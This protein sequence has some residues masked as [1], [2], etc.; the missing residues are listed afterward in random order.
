VIQHP[1]DRRPAITPQLAMRVA[2]L[3]GVAFALFAIVFFRLWFLQVLTGDQYL[4][5]A[6]NNRVRDVPF[7]APR[8][9]IVDRNGTV[10]VSSRAALTVQLD[11]QKVPAVEKALAAEYGRRAAAA[12]RQRRR[13]HAKPAARVAVPPLPA[14]ARELDAL[15]RRLGR[16]LALSP[17]RIHRRVV[18]QLAQTPYANVTLKTDVPRTVSGYLQERQFQFPGLEV[19]P[20]YL[21]K[22]PNKRLA[23]QL[24]GTVGQISPDELGQERFRGVKQG[25]VVGQS[26][27]EY[28]Y[29]RYLRG[30]DGA[31]KVQVNALGDQKGVVRRDPP[32]AGKQLKLS[33]DLGLQAEGQRA[34]QVAIGLANRNS[35]PANAGGFVA[36]DPRDGAILAMGSVPSFDPNVF[37]RPLSRSKF[38]AIRD[39]PG[40]PL[41]NRAL[42]GL[43]PTGST[44]KPITA[45]A[46][47][48]SGVIDPYTNVYDSGC[49][50][51]GEQE[52]CNAGKVPYGPVNITRAL[53]VSSDVFFYTMGQ[54]LNPLKG[55]PLQRWARRLGLGRLTGVDVPGEVTGTVP[56]R[57]WRARVAERELRCEKRRHVPACGISDKRPWTVGDNVNLAVG[58][59]DLQASPLQMAVA[60]AALAN[61]G[62]VVRPHLGLEAEDNAGRV[63]QRIDPGS[64]RHVPM[65]GAA[66][67]AILDG[68]HLAASTPQGTSGDVFRGWPQDVYPVYGKTGTAQ[69]GLNPDQSWYVCFVP[70]KA[71]PIVVAVTIEKGGFGAEAAAPAA[72]LILSKWFNIRGKVVA[73]SSHTR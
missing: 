22:Y 1:D 52:R 63:L 56:D 51:I 49:I 55:Q 29:D 65:N 40:A 47:M 25:T 18:E 41:Y 48:S 34:M 62:R 71:R 32:V 9:D 19:Q 23:A 69:R 3:G 11:A 70:N 60:Y 45:L 61:G 68:L 58:Q 31:T 26:G 2:I 27:I 53:Q 20:V 54:D 16:V 30:R 35:N 17:E 46:A 50:Q 5:E 64:A 36:M 13:R 39:Q 15:Y 12:E 4:A 37:S 6:N 44:F 67:A 33:V 24:F 28:A 43:Y 10:L 57:A 66:R 73:G 59:G 42:S 14:S 38:L 72:R 8:G 21:R 7:P